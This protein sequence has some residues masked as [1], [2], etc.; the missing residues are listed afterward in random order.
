MRDASG[1][2]RAGSHELLK[3]FSEF[4]PDELSSPVPSEGPGRE[5]DDPSKETASRAESSGV[6]MYVNHQWF[7]RDRRCRQ[8]DLGLEVHSRGRLQSAV[9]REGS[10]VGTGWQPFL[11]GDVRKP[12]RVKRRGRRVPRPTKERSSV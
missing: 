3:A 4:D 8:V 12:R 11:G 10:G 7:R 9:W 5:H 2:R 1:N 6:L